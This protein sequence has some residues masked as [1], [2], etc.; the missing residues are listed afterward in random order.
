MEEGAS[1]CRLQL[2]RN[3]ASEDID[4]YLFH[5]LRE[6]FE[7]KWTKLTGETGIK[8]KKTEQNDGKKKKK[9]HQSMHK[10]KGTHHETLISW[11]F[12]EAL[13]RAL[14]CHRW[15]TAERQER[16]EEERF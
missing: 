10:W 9:K 11:T 15:K 8:E 13:D 4:V 6:A 16:E 12:V 7:L 5:A 1:R 14:L 2:H 3:Q